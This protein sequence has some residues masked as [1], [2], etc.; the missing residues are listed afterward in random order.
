M[1][2][3]R[4]KLLLRTAIVGIVI[5]GIASAHIRAN[6]STD[7]PLNPNDFVR[8][9]LHHEI[10]AQDQDHSLWSFREK[11]RED[12]K[13]KFYRAYQTRHGQIERLIAIDGRPLAQ[14]EV[15]KEDQ[16][17][18]RLISSPSDM[19]QLQKKQRNDG[20]QARNLL[21]TFPDAFDFQYH[22]TQDGLVRLKFTPKPTFH[23]PNHAAQAFHHMEGTILLDPE[24]K[25]LV[26]IDGQLTS[27]VKFFGGLLGH[28]DKGG[29]FVVRQ[30][31][32]GGDFWEVTEMHVHM[33]GRAL[34]FKTIGVQEDETYFDFDP[35]P[36][37]P[38]LSEAAQFLKGDA[39]D[40]AQAQA[41]K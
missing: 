11:K 33:S 19:R 39:Q 8:D 41:R 22:G 12:G 20:D 27:E 7:L 26:A 18:N 34:L 16:R 29:T 37:N 3:K 4:L 28:L 5:G 9:V 24:Q 25:R 1:P 40:P 31:Q 14:T 35:I 21:S 38:S 6:F 13:W 17:I 23:P 2:L 10:A 32:V 15:Q 36:G 30:R